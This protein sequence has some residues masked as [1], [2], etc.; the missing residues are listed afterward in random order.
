MADK[1]SDRIRTV[2]GDTGEGRGAWA[3]EAAALEQQLADAQ[4]EREAVLADVPERTLADFK[5]WA[6]RQ[7]RE[8]LDAEGKCDSLAAQLASAKALLDVDWLANALRIHDN[9]AVGYG[10]LAERILEAAARA[11]GGKLT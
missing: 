9:S 10:L 4:R 7:H 2:Y 3:G 5:A 6:T 11:A 1:L 8:K